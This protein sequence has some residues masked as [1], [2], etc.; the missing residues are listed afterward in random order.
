MTIERTINN[1]TIKIELTPEELLQAYKERLHD[2]DIDAVYEYADWFD[3][4]RD[5]GLTD[6]QLDRAAIKY[7]KWLNKW[8]SDGDVEEEF[9]HDA[10]KE[11]ANEDGVKL[12]E[13]V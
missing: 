6:E 5:I 10:F 2:F 8:I 9:A 3:D 4:T 12:N 7:R 1:E 13:E 11:V